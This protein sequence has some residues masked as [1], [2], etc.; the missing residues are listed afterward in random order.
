MCCFVLVLGFLGPRVAFLVYW[1]AYPTKTMLASA[2]ITEQQAAE[3]TFMKGKGCGN[4][5][6]GGYRG[7]LGVFEL[8]LMSRTG[9]K[10][11][12]V[13][14]AKGIAT[15]VSIALRKPIV[16]QRSAATRSSG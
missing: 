1:L 7:R 14:K 16:N 13:R 8:M 11:I 9:K 5:Q 2:G 12:A 15:I 4:C 10:M 6:G 3:A